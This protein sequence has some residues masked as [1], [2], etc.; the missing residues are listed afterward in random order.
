MGGEIEEDEWRAEAESS[1]LSTIRDWHFIR[2]TPLIRKGYCVTFTQPGLELTWL[3][4]DP[5][6]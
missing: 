5:V 3:F 6:L 4:I 2:N 1:V